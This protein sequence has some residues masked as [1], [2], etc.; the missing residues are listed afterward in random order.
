MRDNNEEL[1]LYNVSW[2]L[3]IVR[4]ARIRAE[5]A[6]DAATRIRERYGWRRSGTY[7]VDA[8]TRG[9][10]CCEMPIERPNGRRNLLVATL[11]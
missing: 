6:V 2:G 11:A 10:E 9:D 7:T 3:G 1:K 4:R 8:R 5:N